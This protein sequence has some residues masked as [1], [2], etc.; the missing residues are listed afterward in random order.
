MN[1]CNKLNYVLDK[2]I[3]T[4]SSSYAKYNAIPNLFLGISFIVISIVSCITYIKFK[5]SNTS[6]DDEAY[7]TTQGSIFLL[8]S[9][10]SITI[11]AFFILNELKY[12]K[13]LLM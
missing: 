1:T 4:N 5:R 6:F 13:W 2:M 7:A 12:I 10:F 9:L 8:I 11:G 3:E